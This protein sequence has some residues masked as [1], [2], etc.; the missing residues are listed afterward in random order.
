MPLHPDYDLAKLR[1][2]AKKLADKAQQR[3]DYMHK[4]PADAKEAIAMHCEAINLADKEYGR[5]GQAMHTEIHDLVEARTAFSFKHGRETY[6]A[7]MAGVDV[8][9]GTGNTD[10]NS[11]T[12][13]LLVIPQA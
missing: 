7:W 10:P 1:A 2:E 3:R 5:G 11:I 4:L 9:E 8:T 6:R 12:V 13:S